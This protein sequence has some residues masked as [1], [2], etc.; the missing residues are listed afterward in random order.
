L[1]ARRAVIAYPSFSQKHNDWIQKVRAQ[2]DAYYRLVRPHFTLV[3]R[4]SI[5]EA[6]FV[7]HVKQRTAAV[8]KFTF[9]MRCALVVEDVIGD[10]NQVFLVPDK[11]FSD[12]VKLHDRLYTGILAPEL[13]LD[14]PF[15]PHIGVGNS[16]DPVACKRLADELNGQDFVI[17]GV[18]GSLDIVTVV[19]PDKRIT[20]V[21]TIERI[22]LA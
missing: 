7:A 20:E 14:I 1:D 19:A 8:R 12:I 16:S 5:R 21:K 4:S 13:R 10:M 22:A 15:Y 11:G 9:V 18:V 6:E 17:E 3:F 2:H